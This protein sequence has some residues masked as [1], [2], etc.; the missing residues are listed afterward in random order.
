M[1]PER[2]LQ[3][4]AFLA[5]LALDPQTAEPE[6]IARLEVVEEAL[7]HTSAR[8]GW[9]HERLEF[10]GDAVLRLAA[11]EFLEQYH[12]RLT[13]GQ[14]SA[15]RAQLVSDRWLADLGERCGIDQVW[16]IGPMAAGDRAGRAT[17]R[18]ELSEALIGAIYLTWGGARGG[19]LAVAR[20][21]TPH[22]QH[23]SQELLEDPD[24]HNW[25]SALQ[26]WSQGRGLG[27]PQYLSEQVSSEHGDPRR[28]R[29]RVSLQVEAPPAAAESSLAWGPSRRTAEQEAA[30]QL[31]AALRPAAAS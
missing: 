28:F 26:E 16:L 10:L 5:S 11:A 17:V 13:V 4:L 8:R 20:W 31:L 3:L 27:L 1:T 7:T 9:N 25:K 23:T 21:L 15:L 22:W 2:R 18:A 6:A 14:R 24:R 12:G 30:R 19:L 29:C